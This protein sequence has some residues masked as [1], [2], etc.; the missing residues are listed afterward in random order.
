MEEKKQIYDYLTGIHDYEKKLSEL[1]S[2]PHSDNSKGNKGFLI[3]LS[4]YDNLKK[5]I[6]YEELM[7]ENDNSKNFN[8][9]KFANLVKNYDLKASKIKKVE[10]INVSSSEELIK[11]I[12]DGFKYKIITEKFYDLICD[13]DKFYSQIYTYH[14]YSDN[15]NFLNVSFSRHNNILDEFSFIH[16]NKKL[17][18][19][20]ESIIEYY[21][22]E[23]E[24]NNNILLQ[25]DND[26]NLD[27][28]N[29]NKINK[30]NKILPQK[31]NDN[32]LDIQNK[33]KENMNNVAFNFQDKLKKRNKSSNKFKCKNYNTSQQNNL[34]PINMVEN[35]SQRNKEGF[36]VSENWINQWKKNINYYKIIE[37]YSSNMK[38]KKEEIIKKLYY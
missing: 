7:K 8:K 34:I 5:S 9:E 38:E 35:K 21:N 27:I 12:K 10:Q 31:D 3:K 24:F 26:N 19:L 16:G 29:E 20:T 11:L 28:L 30:D 6:R 18:N 17:I 4:D 32:K 36:L 13:K 14:I 15:I 23:K 22:L 33:N 2:N 37:E 1:Y 25:K